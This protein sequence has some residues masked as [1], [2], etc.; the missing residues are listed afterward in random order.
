MED[1]VEK[2]V[3]ANWFFGM[4]PQHILCWEDW[5]NRVVRMHAKRY[6]VRIRDVRETI[7]IGAY[8]AQGR[9]SVKC[10]N[11][12][13]KGQ[14]YAW[15]EG[16]FCCLTCFNQDF[17][18]HLVCSYFPPERTGIEQILLPRLRDNRCWLIGEPLSQ[19]AEENRVLGVPVPDGVI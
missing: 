14:E 18:H 19:L 5:Y 13:C 16:F 7:Q 10:P 9:W 12:N 3:T 4:G 15:Q 8:V 2:I 17:E 1:Y 11:K 6:G